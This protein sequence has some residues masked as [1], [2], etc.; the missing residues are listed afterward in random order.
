MAKVEMV[1]TYQG[2]TRFFLCWKLRI[3][4]VGIFFAWWRL[5]SKRDPYW[6][7]NAVFSRILAILK[8][9]IGLVWTPQLV[10]LK[11]CLCLSCS[12]VFMLRI[13]KSLRWR[14]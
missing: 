12:V 8:A 10:F 9:L 3:L 5:L 2:M 14:N 4:D 1:L 7:N 6:T 11:Y 13:L